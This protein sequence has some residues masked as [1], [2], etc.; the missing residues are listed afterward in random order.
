LFVAEWEACFYVLDDGLLSGKEA[1]GKTYTLI[2]PGW[3]PVEFFQMK[4][5]RR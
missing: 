2:I 1:E 3:N 4:S 5:R